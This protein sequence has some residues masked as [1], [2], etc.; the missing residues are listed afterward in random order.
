ME[1]SADFPTADIKEYDFAATMIQYIQVNHV[2]E[3]PKTKNTEDD[4]NLKETECDFMIVLKA[5]IH[6]TSLDPKLLQLKICK[7]NQQKQKA[8]EEIFSSFQRMY[9]TTRFVN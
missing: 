8:P 9:R 6:K 5:L 7:R 1:P 2:I 3:K 4:E